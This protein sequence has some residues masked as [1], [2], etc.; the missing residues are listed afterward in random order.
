MLN[1]IRPE[2][3]F[4]LSTVMMLCIIQILSIERPEALPRSAAFAQS[5]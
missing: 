3:L 1:R 5:D 4:A 2:L